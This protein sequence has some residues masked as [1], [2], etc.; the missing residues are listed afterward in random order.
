MN[1]IYRILSVIIIYIVLL[2]NSLIAYGDSSKNSYEEAQELGERLGYYDGLLKGFSNNSKVSHY[3]VRPTI[4]KINAEYKNYLKDQDNTYRSNFILGYYNG[5]EKGYNQ[6]SSSNIIDNSKI[7]PTDYPDTLGIILGEI[8]GHRDFYN[9]SR[10][11]WNNALPKDKILTEIYNLNQLTSQDRSGFLKNFKL[12]F[13]EG[14][15]EG[16]SKANFEPV[17]VSYE[18]GMK[19]GEYFGKILGKSSGSKDY[20]NSKTRNYKRDIPSNV[21][22]KR[23]Y[24]LGKD[25]QEYTEGFLV[26][27]RRAYEESYNETFRA[28]NKDEHIRSYQLG[29]EHGKDAGEIMGESYSTKDYY[30]N[31][32]NNWRRY[33]PTQGT[34]IREYGLSLESAWFKD[35]F[36]NGFIEGLSQGYGNIFQKLNKEAMDNKIIVETIP[37]SGGEISSVDKSLILTIDKGIYYN[38]VV[39]TMEQKIFNNLLDKRYIKASDCYSINIANKSKESNNDKDIEIKF[40][41]YGKENGGIFKLVNEKWLYLPS[42]IQDGYIK[43]KVKPSSFKH[44]DNIYMVLVDKDYI[45]LSDIRGHWARE[46]ITTFQRRGIVSGYSDKTFKADTNISKGEFLTMV[47]KAYQWEGLNNIQKTPYEGVINYGLN[48]GY[49]QKPFNPN[50]LISYREVENIMGKVTNSNNFYWY[51]FSSKLLYEKLYRSK[52]YSSKDNNITRAEA[53]YMLYILNEWKY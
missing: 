53:V 32:T 7:S 1:K 10:N 36:I 25:G 14:Y 17:K 28:M 2:N 9:N 50:D 52:S 43:A 39:V 46:E 24:S 29:Y 21:T 5:F 51:N 18:E 40:Q 12:K 8:Y 34:I 27:F 20:F 47:S 11:N 33:I 42:E 44:E 22:I 4:E 35:G 19:D 6:T 23:E 49:I 13:K 30:L 37:I 31:L 16:Y 45:L 38:P 41:Y 26:G 3:E 48:K 15:E